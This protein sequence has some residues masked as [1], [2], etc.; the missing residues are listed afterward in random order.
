MD[1]STPSR[2]GPAK[3]FGSTGI[4]V[5]THLFGALTCTTCW[6]IFG[7]SL[8]LMFGSSGTALLGA[9]RPYAPLALALSAVGLAYSFY[10]LAKSR[11]ASAKLPYRMAATFTLLSAIGWS[12]SAVYAVVTFLKG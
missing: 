5:A 4:A 12:G 1:N 3:I 8:A 9:L 6:A 10:Q 11:N 2:K 7:P